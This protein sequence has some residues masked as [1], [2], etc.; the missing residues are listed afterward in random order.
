MTC[1]TRQ[2]VGKYTYLYESTSY[3]DE[4]KRPR[5]TKIKIGKIDIKTGKPVYTQEYLDKLNAEGKPLPVLKPD[6]KEKVI[7]NQVSQDQVSLT[8]DVLLGIVESVTFYGG[9]YLLSKITEKIGLKAIVQKV[10]PNVWENILDIAYFFVATGDPVMYCSNWISGTMGAREKELSSQRISELFAQ[11]TEKERNS[12]Y[13][14]WLSKMQKV[15]HDYIALDITSVSSY[16]QLMGLIEWGY[17]RDKEKLEQLNI[18]LLLGEGTQLPAYQTPYSGSLNDVRTLLTTLQEV[19][20]LCPEAAM[21]I[22]TDKGFFS[23]FN[24]NGL[25]NKQ[26]KKEESPWICKFLMAVPFTNNF[27]K[28]LVASSVN[29]MYDTY[30]VIDLPEGALY[31]IHKV[32]NWPNI[33]QPLHTFIYLNH[34]KRSKDFDDLNCMVMK[35]FDEAEKDCHNKKYIAS[36]DRYLSIR[37]NAKAPQGY[38]VKIRKD[39]IEKELENNGMLVL[40]SNDIA[41]PKEAILTYRQKDYVEKGFDKLKNRLGLHRLRVKDDTRVYNK[42]LVSFISLIIA[43]YMDKI[44]R[45]FGLYS[46]YTMKE[47]INIMSQLRQGSFNGKQIMQP[48]TKEQKRIMKTFGIPEPNRIKKASGF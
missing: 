17:N 25:I 44:M 35:L 46:H 1:I 33:E 14:S 38:T 47:L 48:L 26:E 8:S 9:Y 32:C 37:K 4:L 23:T 7:Q 6:P 34:D 28:N 45:D 13:M 41:D 29:V 10:F 27:A 11:I 39:V 3:V 21:K 19:F 20:A 42:L 31:G 24:I 22:V 40:V 5:N 18:C 15:E 30:N 43:C 2:H 36:F 12:F 16:A